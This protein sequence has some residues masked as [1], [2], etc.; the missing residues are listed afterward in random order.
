MYFAPDSQ[1]G[2][3]S[4]YNLFFLGINPDPRAHL[5]YWNSTKID[6]NT[7][8]G[9]PL[10]NWVSAS[11]NLDTHS[12]YGDPLFTD[13]NGPDNILGFTVANGGYDDGPRF[14]ISVIIIPILIIIGLSLLFPT[15]TQVQVNP[16]GG[17]RK[18]STDEGKTGT[19]TL[20]HTHTRANVVVTAN[21]F[22]RPSKVINSPRF[23]GCYLLLPS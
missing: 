18:R 6:L 21:A 23:K 5:A 9:N 15:I 8:G 17:R 22:S 3:D 19:H 12:W 14:D 10:A 20:T 11:G 1:A 4:D 7:S 13:M 16:S 2:I